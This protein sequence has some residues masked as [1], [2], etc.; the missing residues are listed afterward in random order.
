MRLRSGLAVLVVVLAVAVT[1]TGGFSALASDRTADV[2]VAQD[3]T[4]YLGIELRETVELGPGKTNGVRLATLRNNFPAELTTIAVTIEDTGQGP[5]LLESNTSPSS[6]AVG[7]AGLLT[8]DVVCGASGEERWR[9]HIE[10]SGPDIILRTSR[11][12]IVTCTGPRQG[13]PP[14]TPGP[15]DQANQS[16]PSVTPTPPTPSPPDQANRASTPSPAQMSN[17]SDANGTPQAPVTTDTTGPAT[18]RNSTDRGG[19]QR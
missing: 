5:P 8:A 14:A 13:G 17:A 1:A 10:A 9:I 18:P 16:G 3:E 19:G 11:D 15:P 12:V 6:L 2:V 7:R 4:A